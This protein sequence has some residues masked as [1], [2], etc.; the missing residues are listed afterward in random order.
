MVVRRVVGRWRTVESSQVLVGVSAIVMTL[1]ALVV[2]FA[3]F[4]LDASFRAA[5]DSVQAE[6]NS[7]TEL[8]QD[9][10]VFPS[11]TR[12]RAAAAIR[13]YA[14]RVH[15]HEFE[16]MR[17]G[18]EDPATARAF[19]Q[20]VA[21]IQSIRPASP[22]Q[23]AFYRSAVDAVGRVLQER[24]KRLTAARGSLPESFW[25][26]IILTGAVGLAT[27]LLLRAEALAVE[28]LMVGAVGIVVGAGVL[29]TLLLDY[30]FS[31]SIAVSA[32]PFRDVLV[33]AAR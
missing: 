12:L 17:D 14:R 25:V 16:A 32:D 6:A 33:H 10:R 3:V 11:R 19:D 4:T 13:S 24:Q 20:V 2:A 26:L 31:G 1:F 30:P 21:A 27:T 9:L 5:S 8:A 23:N 7:L 29:T 28:L 18:E 15:D 22:V